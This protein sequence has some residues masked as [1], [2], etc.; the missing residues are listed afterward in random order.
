MS[1]EIKFRGQNSFSFNWAVGSL[2]I[3]DETPDQIMTYTGYKH[4][5]LPETVGQYIG[6]TD[7]NELEIFEGDILKCWDNCV[8]ENWSKYHIGFVMY[9]GIKFTLSV[10]DTF[11]DL[12]YNAENIEVIGNIHENP[13]LLHQPKVN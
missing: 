11:L 10:G 13:E 5:I 7:K 3:K 9:D 1:R 6:L 2:L 12:F 8:V 4:D